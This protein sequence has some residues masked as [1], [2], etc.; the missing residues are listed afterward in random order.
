MCV[1]RVRLLIKVDDATRS[2]DMLIHKDP[3]PIHYT[4]DITPKMSPIATWTR[5]SQDDQLKRSS[6]CASAIGSTVYIFGGELQ[7]RHPRDNDVHKISLTSG[8]SV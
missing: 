4:N 7:A 6:V 5:L 8:E 2:S 1:G 3:H